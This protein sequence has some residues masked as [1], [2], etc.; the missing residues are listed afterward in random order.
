[1][2]ICRPEEAGA[3]VVAEAVA[4]GAATAAGGADAALAATVAEAAMV[5]V[6]VYYSC[7]LDFG[8]GAV[9]G[10]KT[11]LKACLPTHVAVIWRER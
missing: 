10:Q 7:V 5:K 8:F 1:M 11:I 4:D 6:L 9:D 3:L 2:G